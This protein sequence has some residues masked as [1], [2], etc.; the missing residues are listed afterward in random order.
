MHVKL[1]HAQMFPI[2]HLF[3]IAGWNMKIKVYIFF[4]PLLLHCRYDL[5]NLYRYNYDYSYFAISESSKA[6]DWMRQFIAIN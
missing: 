5:M 1:S 3:G 2:T 6:K 4:I